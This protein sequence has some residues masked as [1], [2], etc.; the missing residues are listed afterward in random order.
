ISLTLSTASA[1]SS[2]SAQSLLL[3]TIPI[4]CEAFARRE[5]SGKISS[6]EPIKALQ[7]YFTTEKILSL[8]RRANARWYKG[9]LG[10][11]SSPATPLRSVGLQGS[12]WT[13]FL[14]SALTRLL[15]QGVR[16]AWYNLAIIN[17]PPHKGL[18]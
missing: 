9:S 4:G 11:S 18:E 17:G 1:P 3:Y 6:F 8:A 14:L 10:L 13:R 12:P 5:R 16:Q 7:R 2:S 15:W